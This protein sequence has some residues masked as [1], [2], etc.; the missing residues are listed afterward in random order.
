MHGGLTFAK[1][2]P[3]AHE[4]G[5]GWWFGFDCNHSGDASY[6]PNNLPAHEVA[7]R[8]KYLDLHGRNI[9]DNHYWSQAEVERETEHLAEQLAA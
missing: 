4:D 9:Y 5:T 2:E 8:A 6:D 3:C 7:F 1:V